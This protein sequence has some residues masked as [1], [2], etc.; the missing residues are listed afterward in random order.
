[1]GIVTVPAGCR[2]FCLRGSQ[3]ARRPN[4][5]PPA[6]LHVPPELKEIHK[7]GE[8]MAPGHILTGPI[9]V[10][11]ARPGQTLEVRILDVTLRQDWGYNLIVPLMG[12]L[13]EDFATARCVNIPLDVER[14]IARTPWGLELPPHPCLGAMD[15]APRETGARSR[16][17]PALPRRQP[18]TT[19]SLS[20]R[21]D[22]LSA[23]LHQGRALLLRRRPRASRA[24]AKSASRPSKPPCKGRS[25]SSCASIR[26]RRRRAITSRWL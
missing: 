12:A 2:R 15:V 17:Y 9:A 1:M 3:E 16:R 21:G 4:H 13:P 10:V 14:K 5:L 7:R 23:D 26:A 11:G 6:G 20:R 22:A 18:G 19:R 24:T 8:R 25:N